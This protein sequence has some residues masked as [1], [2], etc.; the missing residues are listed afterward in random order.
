LRFHS[1]RNFILFVALLLCAAAG[2]A[3]QDRADTLSPQAVGVFGS[4]R[5]AQ[6]SGFVTTPWQLSIGYQYNRIAVPTAIAPF[7]TNGMR[8][9]LTRYFGTLLGVE[10]EVGSGAGRAAPGVL[11]YS[12]FAGAGPRLVYRTRKRRWEPW[13]HGLMGVEHFNFGNIPFPGATTSVAWV[14]GGGVDYRLD[15]GL[16]LRVQGDYLGSLLAG[17]Y[18]RNTQVVGGFVWNF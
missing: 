4:Q 12:I 14:M 17:V 13:V 7:N 8:A 10:A 9:S 15:S 6:I 18:Q 3:A 1:I 11:A 16:G 2:A 5:T